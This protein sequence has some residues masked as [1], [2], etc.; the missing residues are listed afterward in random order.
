MYMKEYI[1][2]LDI[3]IAS[4]L[5]DTFHLTSLYPF[6][7]LV[8]TRILEQEGLYGKQLVKRGMQ[9]QLIILP[10]GSGKSVCFTLTSI[11]INSVILI[12][13]P[14][15]SLLSDQQRRMEELGEHPVI[16]KGGQTKEERLILFSSIT[17]SSSKI[18]L[19]TAE[20]LE[21]QKV[22]TMLQSVPIGLMVV[23]EAHVI[24]LWGM[25]FRPSYL[26]LRE[27]VTLLKPHQIL[28]FTATADK[29]IIA[30]INKVLS[31]G[32]WMHLIKGNIDR[33]NIYYKVIPTL[34]K[35]VTLH[36]LASHVSLRPMIIF[37]SSR[38]M[39]EKV[40]IELTKRLRE[41]ISRYYHARLDKAERAST[42]KWF[43]ESDNGIL[44]AT[45]AYGMG[46]DKKNI[47]SV[48]HYTL[49]NDVASFLQ[50]SGRGGRDGKPTL[51]ASL[52][53]V[54]EKLH[55][56]DSFT[57]I[58][59]HSEQCRRLGMLR[60]MDSIADHCSGCDVCDHSF[61]P[62]PLG[63]KQILHAIKNAPFRFNKETL[64]HHLVATS[65]VPIFRR[66]PYYGVLKN[67]RYEDVIEAIQTLITV[68]KIKIGIK[69]KLYINIRIKKLEKRIIS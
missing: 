36:L 28:A 15:L 22:R 69:K 52:V 8:I 41:P 68:E 58:F 65:F 47:R 55:G 54:G 37:F 27:S 56:D 48:I 51:S 9:G 53:K 13:Y 5:S 10:T 32:K 45:S 46:V 64:S 50:E 1:H 2:P 6:Q 42:E 29:N 63:E 16:I 31:P 21:Q 49:S 33:E 25:S 61:I 59:T 3:K 20:A 66:S 30:I 23:D 43:F 35:I 19:T 18:V 60:L 26:R 14:L 67:W 40:A 17:H 11:L 62:S 39:C 7:Q 38:V 12:V 24:A 57:S 4:L 34:S 44:C